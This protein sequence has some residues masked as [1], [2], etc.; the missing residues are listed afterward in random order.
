MSRSTP[1]PKPGSP[2]R[3][4][5]PPRADL[6][7]FFVMLAV[8][9]A[10]PLI[11][12]SFTHVEFSFLAALPTTG[13]PTPGTTS[14]LDALLLAASIGVWV[15]S[16]RTAA[17]SRVALPALVLLGV[18]V[19]VSTIAADD[20]RLAA[21]AGSHLSIAAL[22]GVALLR[23]MVRPWMPRL[24]LAVVLA[25]ASANAAKCVLQTVSELPDTIE[26]WEKQK[27][28]LVSRGFD[29]DN[30]LIVNF[31]RRVYSAQPFGYLFHPN[32]TASCMMMGLLAAA[33]LL[34]GHVGGFGFRTRSAPL[35]AG[36]CALLAVGIWL[37]DSKGAVLSAGVGIGLLTAF[38]LLRRA[39]LRRPRVTFGVLGAGYLLVIA[40]TAGF[41]LTRGTLPGTSLAFRWQYWTAA[42]QTVAEAPLSGIGRE[43][44]ADAYMR[45]KRPEST[46]EVRN[47]HNLWLTLLVELG[48]LGLIAGA[49]LSGACLFGAV[50]RLADQ[51][52]AT[53]GPVAFPAA[54]AVPA[55]VGVL[56]VHALFAGLS[57]S[58]GWLQLA[59]TWLL[60]LAACIWLIAR[61]EHGGAHG[62]LVA[63]I[64]AALCGSLLHNLVGFS[65]LTAAGLA[66]F[67]ALAAAAIA[68]GRPVPAQPEPERP[69]LPVIPTFVG[70]VLLLT[71]VALVAVPTARAGVFLQ[72]MRAKLERSK[73][74]QDAYNA[75]QTG[76]RAVAADRWDPSAPR[77]VARAALRLAAFE[78]FPSAQ[79]LAWLALAREQAR[80]A[81]ERNPRRA[82]THSLL[83]SVER[84]TADIYFDENRPGDALAE[85]RSAAEH[86]DA[87]V[88]LYPTNPHGRVSAAD[89]QY[90]IWKRSADP[91]NARAAATHLRRA[92]E[93]NATRK[94]E[95]A[96]RLR[97]SELDQIQ[98]RLEE[99]ESAAG[100]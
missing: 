67:V 49:L 6:V 45:H 85:L 74:E 91:E 80:I 20:K 60:A 77:A 10:R 92:L 17:V 66:S 52:A 18:A 78:H 58:A 1:S 46:E 79:R 70:A 15:R 72:E 97:A 42:A 83:G 36:V 22:A 31:E 26:E 41:G 96:D 57:L 69:R 54:R 94:P 16:R 28:E 84:S 7:L 73:N 51:P 68:L 21:N 32:V 59:S 81:L 40:A 35:A 29:L 76:R 9:G 12:E 4:G 48:P 100:S 71:H 3:N 47:P 65:L 38:G 19:V 39:I 64:V 11:P 44:F 25:G 14:G 55:I 93:I 34:A 62:W 75:L 27:V 82:A 87:A 23:V 43:N 33:G 89:A 61:L 50:R 90:R 24:L 86:Y 13:G 98:G 88:E 95:V 8:L 63:G 37:T 56:G 30:P 2:E 5:D 99:L 53:A